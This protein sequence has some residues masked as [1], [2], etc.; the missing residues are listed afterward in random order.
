MSIP[1]T[2]PQRTF[3]LRPYRPRPATNAG[4]T[5]ANFP[6][7]PA[8]NSPRPAATTSLKLRFCNLDYSIREDVL[9]QKLTNAIAGVTKVTIARTHDSKESLGL[10]IR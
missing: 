10:R 3:R 1:S 6:V 2:H 5:P 8:A 4:S 7:T 9:R